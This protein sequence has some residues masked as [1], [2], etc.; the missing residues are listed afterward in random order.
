MAL[1]RVPLP[2]PHAVLACQLSRTIYYSHSPARSR[3]LLAHTTQT[4]SDSSFTYSSGN[5]DPGR[6]FGHIAISVDDVQVECDRLTDKGVKFKKRPEDGKMRH[7][8]F[9]Y[10]P[11]GYW[12]EVRVHLRAPARV[13][14]MCAHRVAGGSQ[15]R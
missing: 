11:D 2:A 5:E 9:I 15:A 12:I 7:I 6:G 8:A 14:V 13:D 1:T 3:P 10:D 4:E